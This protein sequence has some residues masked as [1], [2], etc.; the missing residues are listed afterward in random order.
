MS[1]SNSLSSAANGTTEPL[2]RVPVRHWNRFLGALWYTFVFSFACVLTILCAVSV[3][4]LIPFTR[5]GLVLWRITV[6][7]ART[8]LRACGVKVEVIQEA[9]LPS[10][11]VIFLSNHQSTLD[12]LALF[13]GLPRRF[14]F[15]A[16]KVVFSYPFL[17]WAINAMRY[18]P[19]DRS[20]REAAIRSL[21]A[22]GERI[23]GGL[24]VTAFPEG[25][26][27]KDGSVLPF[28]KG[29][30]ML[31]LQAKV[32]VVPVAVEGS[33]HV[34]PKNKWYLCPNTIRICIGAPIPTAHLT[35]SDRNA[36]IVAVRSNVVRMNQRM[37][38]PGGDET[39]HIA[40]AGFEGVGKAADEGE[41]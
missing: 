41:A 12:I 11:P 7:W 25:T 27:S 4:C 23:R 8:I 20:N 32:P 24:T 30:F 18:I 1:E 34:N 31:A 36:L 28:K 21:A 9:P 19:V 39:H 16:K 15:V 14:V 26:R 10:G 40:A 29:P 2:P 37:H 35:E 13:V 3:L 5:E 38:G 22:A 6:F 17:G 33:Q